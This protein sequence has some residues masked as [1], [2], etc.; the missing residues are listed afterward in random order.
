[1]G[2]P[3]MMFYHDGRH[4]HIYMYEPPMQKEEYE[5]AINELSGTTV[6]AVMFGLAEGR[7][8]LHDTKAGELWG[9]NVEKWPHLIWRRTHQNAKHLI[10]SGNDPLMLVCKRAH[11]KGMLLYP[12]LLV[13]VGS[14]ERGDERATWVRCSNFR[15]D[16]KHLEIRAS[17][18]LDP[19][20]PGFDGLDFKHQE[21]R[22]ERFSIVEEVVTNYPVDGLE[23]AMNNAPLYFHP[24]EI[25]SGRNIMTEWIERVHEVVRRSGPNRELA[26]R[27]PSSI[28][29]C[30]AIGLDVK[31]WIRQGIVDV[32]IGDGALGDT[33][34][35]MADFR[36]LV[37]AAQDS[38]CRVH[39]AIQHRIDSDRV[40]DGTIEM[41]RAAACN[42]WAQGIDGLYMARGWFYNY[43]YEATFYE[44]LR[45]MPQ[46]DI[47][48]SKDKY[49]RLPSYGAGAKPDSGPGSRMDLPVI[50]KLNQPAGI[51]FSIS[52]DLPRWDIVGR[53]YE[54]ML[55]VSITGSTE[56]DRFSF[57]LNGKELPSN[58][59]RK[60][61]E[62]I[63]L[64]GPRGG[65]SGGY[66][67]V[68]TLNEDNWP[69]KGNNLL[70]VTLDH[71]D[72]DV[73]SDVTVRQ[74]ELETKYLMGKNFRRGFVD[75]ALGPYED[76]VG[77]PW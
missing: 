47:M 43:P 73:I 46:P 67:F 24:D 5:A 69:V 26:I 29:D 72:P 63:W 54:V 6:E 34:Q 11:E 70:E 58:M 62:M 39:A 20:G 16:N 40:G 45:E 3:T 19:N 37:K 44:K 33:M 61:N 21:V 15:F 17:G 66:W 48:A 53:V 57:C 42:Y 32:V 64:T 55:R 1:M 22:D 7:T 36:P 77:G 23:L 8:F 12:T 9:H 14:D 56:L 41:V 59:L 13:Q 38:D 68:Y 65:G 28:D 49:Y 50:L 71:R 76:R 74:V 60:I 51:K 27:V 4:N 25:E 10:E 2:K 31:E 75:P 35:Q 52:D 18:D 30:M